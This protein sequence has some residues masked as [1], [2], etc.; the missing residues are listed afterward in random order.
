MPTPGLMEPFLRRQ[1]SS[2]PLHG[3]S[4][5]FFKMGVSSW[6]CSSAVLLW[7][8][9]GGF[10]VLGLILLVKTDMAAHFC[11]VLQLPT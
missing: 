7:L 8:V 11:H 5:R 10:A 9:L 3:G 6:I 2:G 1:R 4:P